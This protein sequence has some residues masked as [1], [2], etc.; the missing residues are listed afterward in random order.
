MKLKNIG[1]IFATVLLLASSVSANDF[2]NISIEP[3]SGEVCSIEANKP[4]DSPAS[5]CDIFGHSSNTYEKNAGSYTQTMCVNLGDKCCRAVCYRYVYCSRCDANIGRA[6]SGHHVADNY[7]LRRL[8]AD[9]VTDA[10]VCKT[11]RGY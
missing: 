2:H 6:S 4:V 3:I 9:G 1:L 5:F 8:V 7:C 11:C 10:T